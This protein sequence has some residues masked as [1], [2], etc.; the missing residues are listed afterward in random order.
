M[1]RKDMGEGRRGRVQTRPRALFG[2]HTVGGGLQGTD[3][4]LERELG[5][6]DPVDQVWFATSA[7]AGGRRRRQN[8][9]GFFVAHFL[10]VFRVNC[11]PI[12]TTRRRG[13]EGEDEGKTGKNDTLHV[14]RG[15]KNLHRNCRSSHGTFLRQK[16]MHTDKQGLPLVCPRAQPNTTVSLAKSL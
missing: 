11:W 16:T 8:P 7:H 2:G 14:Y 13:R 3:E 12:S 1:R 6:V 4:L 10:S 5:R 15:A 9:R